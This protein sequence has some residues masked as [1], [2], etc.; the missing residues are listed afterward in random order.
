MAGK[1]QIKVLATSICGALHRVKNLPCQDFSCAKTAKNKLVAV[2]SDGAG[3]APYGKTG[4]RIICETVC[5]TLIRSDI[6]NIRQN[7]VKAIK[8]ARNK[9]LL[10]RQNKSKSAAELINFS[11]T[12]VGVFYHNNQGIFFHIGDG[13]AIAFNQGNYNN[14]IVSEPENGNFS[15]ET[16]FY[17]MSDWQD[18]LRFTPFENANRVMLMT[19]G[20]TG[21]VF[22]DNF[23]KLQRKF[24]VPV[25][26]YLEAEKRKTYALQALNNTL[27]DKQAQRINADDK[28]LLWA[29]L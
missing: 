4:A 16:Y 5:D 13:A 9:L 29:K 2:V 25:A 20:V 15:C 27:N 10:H 23:Y 17:T 3:S 7:V 12:M 24:F 14:F 22:T 26:E 8:I 1:E 28:T 18:C 11:A 21:F 19:D 6:K